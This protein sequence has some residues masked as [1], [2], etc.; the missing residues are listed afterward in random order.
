MQLDGL[1]YL[2]SI[3]DGSTPQAPISATLR[4]VLVGAEPGLARFEGTP[5]ADQHNPMGQIH[6]GWACTLLDSAMGAAVMS[7]LDA[8]ATYTTSQLSVHLTRAI[9][10]DTGP[11]TAEGR[12]V[13]RGR[14]VATAEARLTDAAG[15][16]LAHATCTCVILPRR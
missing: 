3:L 13:H 10:V 1:R 4:F 5:H 14:R 9:T 2:R 16:L 7:T 11:V 15:E 6:G 8:D 12:V